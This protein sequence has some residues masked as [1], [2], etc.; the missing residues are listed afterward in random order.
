MPPGGLER[1]KGGIDIIIAVTYLRD[2]MG[3]N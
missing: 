2:S 1:Y 3:I